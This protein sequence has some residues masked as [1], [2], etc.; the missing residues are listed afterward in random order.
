MGVSDSGCPSSATSWSFTV[1]RCAPTARAWERARPLRYDSRCW[2]RNRWPKKLWLL[3]L[4][5]LASCLESVG[6]EVGH[7]AGC[8]ADDEIG[9]VLLR[10][11]LHLFPGLGK[12]SHTL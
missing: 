5:L 8:Y 6:D 4:R 3:L 12:L 1:D 10:Q 9:S 2:S 11:L 7:Q